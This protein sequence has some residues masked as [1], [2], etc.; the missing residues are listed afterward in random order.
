A[1]GWPP[2]RR[3]SPRSAPAN[4]AATP[5]PTALRSGPAPP[6]VS[7]SAP[8]SSAGGAR[9]TRRYSP[10]AAFFSCMSRS[11]SRRNS[12][13]VSGGDWLHAMP[14]AHST[15]TGGQP[16]V[17]LME[18][19]AAR[20]PGQRIR[21]VAGELAVGVVQTARHDAQQ[22]VRELGG[23]LEHGHEIA[24][25]DHEALRA[26]NGDDGGRARLVTQDPELTEDLGLAE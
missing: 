4:R 7:V 14:V 3:S 9:K 18:C 11:A 21:R 1:R 17:L 20:E 25:A 19:A 13:A 26:I 16:A 6:R 23:L 15:E 12:S 8:S 24:L 2:P 10:R 22:R 5:R